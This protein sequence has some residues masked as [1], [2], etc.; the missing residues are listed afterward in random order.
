MIKVYYAYIYTV[1][2][3][4]IYTHIIYTHGVQML[5]VGLNSSIIKN[6]KKIYWDLQYNFIIFPFHLFSSN[7]SVNLSLLSFKF[8]DPLLI[9]CYYY[10]HIFICICIYIPTY[11]LFSLYVT[12]MCVFRTDIIWYWKTNLFTLPW[13]DYF[14]GSQQ[15][16]VVFSFFFFCKAEASWFFFSPPWSL[17]LVSLFN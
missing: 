16:L 9:N 14:S 6:L 4:Y 11:N 12:C 5:S 10:V 7:L 13:E 3:I 1:F 2:I 15:T 8:K 17:L